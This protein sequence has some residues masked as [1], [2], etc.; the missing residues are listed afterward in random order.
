M[1]KVKLVLAAILEE[2]ES[3][4]FDNQRIKLN[5]QQGQVDQV[6]E[7]RAFA[8]LIEEEVQVMGG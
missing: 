6:E 5:R 2:V 4:F 7:E 8:Q 1:W 3:C